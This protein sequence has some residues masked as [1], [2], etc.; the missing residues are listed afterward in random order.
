MTAG[1]DAA[2]PPVWARK[3]VALGTCPKSYITAESQTLMEE[4]FV[5]RRMGGFD[6][7]KLSM[8]QVEAFLILERAVAAEVN[9]EQHNA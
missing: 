6:L 2:L 9:D 7:E 4:F 5:R 1:E 3:R 8:R